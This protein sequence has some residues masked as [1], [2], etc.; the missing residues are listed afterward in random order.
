M[1]KKLFLLISL[2][3]LCTS[4]CGCAGTSYEVGV[5]GFA[6]PAYAGGQSY[7]LQSGKKE[8]AEDNL[9][10]QE[11][12]RYVRRGLAEAGF[13]VS[14]SIEQADLVVF[15]SYGIGDAKDHSYSV[16]IYGLTGGGTA[17]F[18]GTSYS[19]RYGSTT[20]SG[21]VRQQ[22]Q[23]GVVG[24]QEHTDTTY[25]R[26]LLVDAIDGKAYRTDK[27]TVS[28][29]KTD[30]TSRGSSSDLREVFP[31]LVVAATPHFG[32]DTKKRVVIDISETDKRLEQMRSGGDK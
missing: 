23:F 11:Y 8:V 30:V 16:P 18:S 24:S 32:K 3:A 6:I 1:K 31:V 19:P 13:T 20:T 2:A 15:L 28:A 17:T 29:W 21:T 5:S 7:W 10:F 26:Y 9:E 4:L 25:S 22:P 14:P 27:K 12:A